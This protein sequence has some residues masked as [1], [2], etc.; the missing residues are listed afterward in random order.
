MSKTKIAQ[1][2][3]GVEGSRERKSLRN[4]VKYREGLGWSDEA[5]LHWLQTGENPQQVKAA[6]VLG[7][8][9]LELRDSDIPRHKVDA[10]IREMQ[11]LQTAEL[12]SSAGVVIEMKP[13]DKAEPEASKPESVKAHVESNAVLPPASVKSEV[14]AEPAP[15]MGLVVKALVLASI[16]SAATYYLVLATIP[17]YGLIAAIL[18]E[19]MPL[20][21]I[22]FVRSRIVKIAL[23]LAFAGSGFYTL[24]AIRSAEV[25]EV[26]ASALETNPEYQRLTQKRQGLQAEH[27]GLDVV[28]SRTRRSQIREELKPID[29]RMTEIEAVAK[30]STGKGAGESKADVNFLVRALLYLGSLVLTHALAVTLRAIPMQPIMDR[31]KALA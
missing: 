20:A 11:S 23:V 16:I 24:S 12:T 15:V 1:F 19:V 29:T 8:T 30:S 17:V 25:S 21:F 13:K 2:L 26:R 27:D 10:V 28:K 14:L 3:E 22:F 4:S 6:P 31:I 9:A 5:I 18:L 7:A